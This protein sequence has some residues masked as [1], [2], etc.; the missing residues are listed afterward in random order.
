MSSQYILYKSYETLV[1]EFYQLLFDF[2]T[3]KLF[4]DN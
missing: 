4:Y 1:L 3:I 2:T